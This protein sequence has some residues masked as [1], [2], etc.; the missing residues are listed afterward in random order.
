[1]IISKYSK[2]QNAEKRELRHYF[3]YGLRDLALSYNIKEAA[4]MALG[5]YRDSAIFIVGRR[6]L[7]GIHKEIGERFFGA[8]V[9]YCS[10]YK[11]FNRVYREYKKYIFKM[12]RVNLV[13]KYFELNQQNLDLNFY[14]SK[15]IRFFKS[16]ITDFQPGDVKTKATI[17]VS[18]EDLISIEQTTP[19]CKMQ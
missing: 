14:Q 19:D 3:L 11:D 17:E 15:L 18:N 1:M 5:D 8:E 6:H 9:I 16:T 13:D 12:D 10:D 2:L 4:K 7:D